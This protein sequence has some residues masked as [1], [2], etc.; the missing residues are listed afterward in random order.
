MNW[1]RQSS[2]CRSSEWGIGNGE[3]EITSPLPIPYFPFPVP[4]SPFPL[5]PRTLNTL[6]SPVT[7]WHFTILR[8]GWDWSQRIPGPVVNLEIIDG[9]VWLQA[10]NT[11]LRIAE[12]LEEAG[13]AKSDIVLGFQPLRVRPYTEYAVA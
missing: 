4:Y 2:D 8:E 3:W 6:K 11:D 7:L 1:S 12:R 5:Q 10:D 9:K 13:I